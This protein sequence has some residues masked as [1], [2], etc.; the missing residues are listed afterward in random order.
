M[1]LH[2]NETTHDIE[3]ATVN[4]AAML[5]FVKH[6]MPIITVAKNCWTI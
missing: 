4:R 1:V 2:P 6:N 3:S 5:L